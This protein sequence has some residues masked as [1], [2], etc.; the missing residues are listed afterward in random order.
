MS[1]RRTHESVWALLLVAACLRAVPEGPDADGGPAVDALDGG[2]GADGAWLA[3]PDA[4]AGAVDAAAPAPDGSFTDAGAIDS[5]DVTCIAPAADASGAW[6]DAGVGSGCG[7]ILGVPMCYPPDGTPP[8]VPDAGCILCPMGWVYPDKDRNNCGVCGNACVY[9]QNCQQGVC[10][11]WCGEGLVCASHC[12]TGCPDGT[13]PCGCTPFNTP[14]CTDTH[15]QDSLNCGSCGARCGLGETCQGGACVPCGDG[16]LAW[17]TT[18]GD[19]V[20]SGNGHRDAGLAPCTTESP[21]KACSQR[22]AYCDP[23]D[24]CNSYL[25]CAPGDPRRCPFPCPM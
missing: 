14:H 25:L 1:L 3:S 7:V 21:G 12:A 24:E 19:H 15:G 20:C 6:Q 13:E 16:G 23:G 11:S 8:P 4:G 18:C 9:G 10:T 22:G 17:W 2:P 5:G